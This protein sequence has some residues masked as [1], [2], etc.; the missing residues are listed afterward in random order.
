MVSAT[1]DPSDSSRAFADVT[2]LMSVPGYL[3]S[4]LN[5]L[6]NT[7]LN[8]ISVFDAGQNATYMLPFLA[9]FPRLI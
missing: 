9:A 3:S 2:V 7:S 5:C 1:A 4:F 6:L 8:I